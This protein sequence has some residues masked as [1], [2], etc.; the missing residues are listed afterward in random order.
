VWQRCTVPFVRNVLARVPRAA[1]GFVA[2]ARKKLFSQPTQ[3]EARVALRKA[4]ALLQG[5]RPSAGALVAAAEEDVLGHM[6]FPDKR[7][8]PL[9]SIRDRLAAVSEC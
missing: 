8:R 4:V 6:S 3:A 9:Y 1:Q 7:W 2:A 5:K